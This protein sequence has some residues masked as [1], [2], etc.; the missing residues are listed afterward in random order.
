MDF[1]LNLECH[2]YVSLNPINDSLYDIPCFM[3]AYIS[4]ISLTMFSYT[5]LIIYVLTSSVIF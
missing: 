3:I 4:C 1:K 5:Y 2:M